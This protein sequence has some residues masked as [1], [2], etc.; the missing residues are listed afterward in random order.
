MHDISF[1]YANIMSLY[2]YHFPPPPLD[3]WLYHEAERLPSSSHKQRCKARV[4]NEAIRRTADGA[5]VIARDKIPQFEETQHGKNILPAHAHNAH[6]ALSAFW[7]QTSLKER[8]PKRRDMVW[9]TKNNLLKALGDPKH[10]GDASIE[11][12]S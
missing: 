2:L 9:L 3:V 8:S 10:Q 1:I 12:K 5:L 11:K 6:L 7:V 4:V